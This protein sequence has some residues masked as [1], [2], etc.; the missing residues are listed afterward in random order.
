MTLRKHVSVLALLLPGTTVLAHDGDHAGMAQTTIELHHY[1]LP[2]ALSAIV[3][4]ALAVSLIKRF[5]I[6]DERNGANRR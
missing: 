6:A 5:S 2:L 1:G 3:L 4:L